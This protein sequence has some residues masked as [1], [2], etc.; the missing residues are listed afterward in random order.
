MNQQPEQFNL[1]STYLRLRS[2]VS[3]EPLPVD[4][5]FW[6]RLMSGELG[7]FHNE[8][9]VTVHAFDVDWS[10]WERHPNGDEVVCLLDGEVTFILEQQNEHHAV[11]L[12]E[13]G[14]YVIVP[15][16]TWHTAEVAAPSRML[17]ITAGEGTEHREA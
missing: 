7:S 1:A 17:F 6:R 15:K 5:T 8:Y 14:A 3:V 9:L 16:G 10:S 4:D 2:D 13:C 11:T 12:D